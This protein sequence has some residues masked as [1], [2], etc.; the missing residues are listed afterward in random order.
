M[1]LFY[2]RQVEAA[3]KAQGLY[4]GLVYP[5]MMDYKWILESNQV[6]NCPVSVEDAKVRKNVG[7]KITLLKGKTTSLKPE[8]V[9]MD[10]VEVLVEI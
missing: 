7:P 10:K 2:K 1:L 3:E 5:S 9:K 4:A 8:L 6:E